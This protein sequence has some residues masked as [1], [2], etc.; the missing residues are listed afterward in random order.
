MC[1][2][3]RKNPECPAPRPGARR[4]AS[5]DLP[6]AVRDS[7][8]E[9]Y[10]GPAHGLLRTQVIARGRLGLG[11]GVEEDVTGE[12]VGAAPGDQLST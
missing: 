5:I 3:S 2:F 1:Y 10:F 12:G 7:E 6:A 9:A 4:I 11:G 8:R